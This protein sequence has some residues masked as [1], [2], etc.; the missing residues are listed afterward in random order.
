MKHNIKN[1]IY[2]ALGFLFPVFLGLITTPYIVHKLTPEVYGIYV[3][4]ISV[5]GLLS[6]LDL[7]FGQGIIKFVSHYEA[8]GDFA[9]INEIINTTLF[10]NT[11][12]GV[13]GFFLVFFSTNFL[14]TKVFKVNFQY[15]DISISAFKI[16]AFGLFLSI[17]SSTF[18]NIPKALQRYDVSVKIQNFIWFSSTITSVVL[19]YLGYG[20]TEILL[21]YI[22]FQLLGLWLYFHTSKRLLPTLKISLFLKKDVFKEIFGFSVYTGINSITGNIVFR[23]DKILIAYFLGTSTVTY[24]QIPFMVVQMSNGFIS[25]IIQ[26]LIP[27]VSFINSLGDKERLKVIYIRYTKYVFVLSLIVF[28]G[29]V[30]FGKPFLILWIG[31]N[32]AEKSYP[33][34]VIISTVFFFISISNVGYYFYNG[35]GK[36]KINMISSFVG[37]V[38]YLLAAF[39]L[40]PKFGLVGSAIAFCFILVPYPVYVFILKKIVEV[41]L[42]WYIVMLC[43]SLLIVSVALIVC[44]TIILKK[45]FLNM[46]MFYGLTLFIISL[47]LLLILKFITKADLMEMKNR[48]VR[49]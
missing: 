9:R 26:F 23:V 2:N 30:F 45:D 22:F 7:G 37:S 27:V 40:I 6:F 1:A 8:K 19:L 43:K 16:T 4:A 5:M 3:L 41:S 31:N 12:M 20:L 13:I 35:L 39:W 36:S 10:I 17:V 46:L 44:Y 42:Q 47:F 33:L 24:Y 25:S 34:L 15:S 48:M 32:I 11:I 38:F 49:I 29:L 21:S 28:S 18:S 14:T